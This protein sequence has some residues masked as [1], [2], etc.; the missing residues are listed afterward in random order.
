M[1]K[2]SHQMQMLERAVKLLDQL[3][4]MQP[5]I[6]KSLAEHH[7]NLSYNEM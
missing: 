3:W 2:S 5:P 6:I 4:W 7:E 1:Q